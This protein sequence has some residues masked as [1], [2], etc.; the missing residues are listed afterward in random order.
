MAI[1][2]LFRASPRSSPADTLA[3]TRSSGLNRRVS[4]PFAWPTFARQVA[5]LPTFWTMAYDQF[6]LTVR[7]KKPVILDDIVERQRMALFSHDPHITAARL[8]RDAGGELL[9]AP[10]TT[11]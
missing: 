1:R 3:G 4:R 5:H 2:R 8:S 10:L 7:Q 6:P 9:V 11:K